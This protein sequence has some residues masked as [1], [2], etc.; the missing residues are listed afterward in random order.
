MTETVQ[1]SLYTLGPDEKTAL[2]MAYTANALYWGEVVVKEIIRVSTWLRTNSAP[3]RVHL[4][5]ARMAVTTTNTQA[6]P[7][8]L[9][10]AHV[11]V[12]QIL[13]FH[14]M[15]PAKD[16]VDYDMNEPNRRML[17]VSLLVGN[18]RIDGNLR[19]AAQLSL[20]KYL[21]AARENLT[22][23]YDARISSLTVPTFGTISV[24]HLLVRQ[25]AATFTLP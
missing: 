16:P 12:S 8:Q 18:F 4:Y 13:A 25:E 2:V 1:T 10:E 21:E 24:P 19:L 17:L 23:I 15:P 6:R 5:N 7:I 9:S 3:S 14:L 11:S 22:S 20:A